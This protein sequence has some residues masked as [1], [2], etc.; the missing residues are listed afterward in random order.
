MKKTPISVAGQA[1]C[2]FTWSLYAEFLQAGFRHVFLVI[3]V[4]LLLSAAHFAQSAPDKAS[5]NSGQNSETVYT[6]HTIGLTAPRVISQVDPQFTKEAKRAKIYGQVS[7]L[8]VVNSAGKATNIR[9]VQGL[10][11]GLDEKAIEA[12]G[13]WKFRPAMKDGTPVAVEITVLMD[14][15]KY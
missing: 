7:L 10:G 2:D 12:I 3:I 1:L 15:R 6:A 14:F 8:L 5:E 9:V 13:K 4:V 11:Y